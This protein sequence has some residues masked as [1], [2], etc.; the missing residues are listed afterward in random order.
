MVSTPLIECPK[1]Q[2]KNQSGA[3]FC[4]NCGLPL[5][6]SETK[7]GNCGAVV[8][9]DRRYCGSCGKPLGESD[10]PLLTGNR[11][12]RGRDDFATKVEVSDVEGFFKKG[13]IVE[14]GTKAIF[15]VSGAFAGILEPGKYEMGGLI[16]KVKNLFNSKSTTAVLVDAG[17]VELPI[18]LFDILT[19]DPLKLTVKCRLVV[20]MDNPTLFFENLMKGRQNV[21]TWELE[22]FLRV[23]LQNCMQE[24]VGKKSV[25][26]LSSDISFKQQIEQGIVQ[27]LAKSFG[28]KGLSFIQVRV[29]DFRHERLNALTNKKEEYWLYAQELQTT[30]AGGASTTDLERKVMDQETAKA[31]MAVE[32]FEERAKVYERMRKAAASAEMDKV[33]EAEQLE[34]FL[35]SIDK[36]R[37][38]HQDE[39]DS[40]IR[41]FGEKKEDQNL[42]RQHTIQKLKLEQDA[43]LARAEAMIRISLDRTRSDAQHGEEMAKVEHQLSINRKLL[44]QQQAEEWTSAKQEADIQ[45]Y[46]VE[47]QIDLAKKKKIT[48]VE[49]EELEDQADMRTASASLDLLKKQKGIKKEEADWNLDRALHSRSGMAEIHMKEEAQRHQQELEKIQTLST[50]STEALI[51]SAPAERAAMLTELKRTESLKGFSEDQILAMAAEK[52]PEIAKAFQEKFKSASSADVQ[53][54]Y[55]KMLAMKDQNLSDIKEMSRDHAH[56]VLE[57]YNKGMETQ[58]DTASRAA[59]PG[60]TVITPGGPA[61]MVQTGQGAERAKPRMVVCPK[62]HLETAEGNKFCENCGNKFFD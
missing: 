29:F 36:N 16:E 2:F 1:C 49:L 25:Q 61:G 24:F 54:A 37:L 58:R 5:P 35:H 45:R 38:V 57:M 22:E 52:N 9:A 3:K 60:M 8:P 56:M 19:R 50:L 7:C 4:G 11:W 62:C 27:H 39:M 13:L 55:D 40:L 44:E 18:Y 26:E 30:L 46:K 41:D 14:A 10:S 53:R 47:S 34:D 17:D 12:A 48:E 20:Q 6:G 42:A 31:L 51:A 28:R 33:I 15:F 59:A 21:S 23:E 32:V 43:E